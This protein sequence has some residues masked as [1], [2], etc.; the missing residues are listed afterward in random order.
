MDHQPPTAIMAI[1]NLTTDSFYAP[2]RVGDAAEAIRIARQLLAGDADLVDL[3]AAASNPSAGAV[4]AAEEIAR[5]TPVLEGL[6]DLIARVSVDSFQPAVQ[7]FALDR[8][9]GFL[10]DIQGFGDATIYPA[11]A[12]ASCKLII[13]HATQRGGIA[14]L[15]GTLTARTA[16]DNIICFFEARVAQLEC[17]G[18]AR[19]RLILDPGM[20]YFLSPQPE[21]SLSV[22][23]NLDRLK[24]AFGLPIL[25]SVSRKSF[26]RATT[27][28]ATEALGPA[29][30]AAELHAVARGANFVR[31]HS[32]GE[33]RSALRVEQ[34]LSDARQLGGGSS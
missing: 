21:A 6:G 4:T 20:G 5:L 7:H 22:L 29:S 31:T 10:N 27:G 18:I 15:D 24:S 13:M 33:L 30:L 9:V 8:G 32:P 26:L 23:A 16:L 12:A 19:D 1:V 3:G 34:A 2:S 14:D 25:V 28:L 11:L 17:A